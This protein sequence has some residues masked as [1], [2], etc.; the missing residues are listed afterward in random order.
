MSIRIYGQQ[1]KEIKQG[2]QFVANITS[3]EG[4]QVVELQE[5]SN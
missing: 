5:V 1:A 2:Q 3:V 4:R